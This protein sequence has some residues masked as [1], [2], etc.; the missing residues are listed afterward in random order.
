MNWDSSITFKIILELILP[1]IPYLNQEFKTKTKFLT[2]SIINY[3]GTGTNTWKWLPSTRSLCFIK[4][5]LTDC[6]FCYVSTGAFADNNMFF[7]YIF[8]TL[9]QYASNTW[10]CVFM[11][12]FL[13]SD[14]QTVEIFIVI[15]YSCLYF[16]FYITSFIISIVFFCLNVSPLK[17]CARMVF[18]A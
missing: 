4:S 12:I 6:C 10:T 11:L 7:F 8:L 5:L 16:C 18:S 14:I 2:K 15:F 9:G 3:N 13:L 1:I 17:R